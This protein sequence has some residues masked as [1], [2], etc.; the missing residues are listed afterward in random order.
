VVGDSLR[1]QDGRSCSYPREDIKSASVV[2][3]LKHGYQGE[4][5]EYGGGVRS[6]AALVA[7]V[8]FE[9]RAPEEAAKVLGQIT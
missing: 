2:L 8:R 9:E 1:E 4:M 3:G 6:P 5:H 7:S